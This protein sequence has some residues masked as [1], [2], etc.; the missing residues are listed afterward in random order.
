VGDFRTEDA[1]CLDTRGILSLSLTRTT[2]ERL[3]INAELQSK[4]PRNQIRPRESPTP[5]RILEIQLTLLIFIVI[6]IDLKDKTS[7]S[8]GAKERLKE[9]DSRREAAGEGGWQVLL[10]SDFSSSG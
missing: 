4:T 3:G 8:I 7:L 5:N 9:W 1:W 2:Y 10:S 6:H